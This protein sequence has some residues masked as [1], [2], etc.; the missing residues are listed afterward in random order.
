MSFNELK[1]QNSFDIYFCFSVNITVITNNK[2]AR[3]SNFVENILFN[4]ISKYSRLV[5]LEFVWENV[6]THQTD[7]PKNLCEDCLLLTKV[8]YLISFRLDAC[9]KMSGKSDIAGGFHIIIDQVMSVVGF[10]RWVRVK[11]RAAVG[12]V[13]ALTA[14]TLGGGDSANPP[15]AEE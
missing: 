15:A 8:T 6:K 3:Y 10:Q 14:G 12:L 7:C 13:W 4:F 9:T 1:Q 11:R 2:C 5:N